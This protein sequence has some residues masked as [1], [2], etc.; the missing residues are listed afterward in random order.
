MQWQ[1][2]RPPLLC[3]LLNDCRVLLED[4]PPDRAAAALSETAVLAGGLAAGAPVVAAMAEALRA[5]LAMPLQ[6][7]AARPQA[8]ADLDMAEAAEPTVNTHVTT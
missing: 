6:P 4:L 7:P 5:N 3:S 2:L 1:G 8:T